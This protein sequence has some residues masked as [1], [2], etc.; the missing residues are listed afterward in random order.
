MNLLHESI[1]WTRLNAKPQNNYHIKMNI[2][3]IVAETDR[4]CWVESCNI[5]QM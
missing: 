3:V 5:F 1:Q 4:N 2:E